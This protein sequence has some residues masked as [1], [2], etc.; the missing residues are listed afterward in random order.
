MKS[1]LFLVFALIWLLSLSAITRA[2]GNLL[3]PLFE[4]NGAFEDVVIDHH[5]TFFMAARLAESA[6]P[7]VV[8]FHRGKNGE[9]IESG[10]Y[11]SKEYAH[12]LALKKNYLYLADGEHG[13]EIID[14]SDPAHPKL[15]A[16]Q[17][18]EG[19]THQVVLQGDLA[20]V[21]SGYGGLHIIDIKHPKLP[22][23]L[24]TYQAYAPPGSQETGE[25]EGLFSADGSSTA[26]ASDLYYDFDDEDYG[27]EVDID[28][29]DLYREEGALD[30]VSDGNIVY[31]AYGSAGIVI[32]DISD[33]TKPRKTGEFQLHR[34]AES[35]ALLAN[36]LYV[37]A[38]VTGVLSIDVSDPS[39]P[40]QLGKMRTDCYPMDVAVAAGRAFVA[41]GFCG[42]DGLYVIDVREPKALTTQQRLPG[43]VNNVRI[44]G[45]RLLVMGK[46][47]SRVFQLRQ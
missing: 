35:L 4:I 43:K 27:G 14:V 3:T 38:G 15:M 45:D 11:L 46:E 26:G 23:L 29:A 21:A 12:G 44:L 2:D 33:P 13:L 6:T 8:I 40:K 9:V 10:R 19:Y 25:E 36:T 7:D 16:V 24:S 18:L 42:S 31:L 47:S 17:F 41:D 20:L 22:R 39:A 30:I 32:V 5:E 1:R 34:S 37:T 28:P